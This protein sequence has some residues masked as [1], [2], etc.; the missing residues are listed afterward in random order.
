MR[1]MLDER[2]AAQLDR[3][4][5]KNGIT[6]RFKLV[7]VENPLYTDGDDELSRIEFVF[8]AVPLGANG[9]PLGANLRGVGDGLENGRVVPEVF[10]VGLFWGLC[11]L[12]RLLMWFAGL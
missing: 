1:E 3:K 8:E 12:G 2:D 7:L 5:Q 11:W 6:T 10:L 9:Q 4:A